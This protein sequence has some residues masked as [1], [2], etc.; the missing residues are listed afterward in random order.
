MRLFPQYEIVEQTETK[1]VFHRRNGLLLTLFLLFWVLAFGGIPLGMFVLISS[2]HGVTTLNCQR[3]DGPNKINCEWSQSQYLGLIT[4]VQDRPIKQVTAVK[5]GSAQWSNGQGGGTEKVWVSMAT[6][7]GTTRL[8]ETQFAIESG[9]QPTWQPKVA[10]EV[11]AFLNSQQASL[12]LSQDTRLSSSLWGS[13]PI[14]LP[15]TIIA[16]LVAYGGLRSQTLILDKISNQ[17]KVNTQTILGPR[18][19]TYPLDGVKSIKVKERW[20]EAYTYQLS[21]SFKSGKRYALP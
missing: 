18:T 19:K 14:F 12:T 5:L 20:D 7:T 13:T 16:V 4:K 21:F 9:Y 3:A 2:E 1:L 11:Q 6:P 10:Q 15:F 17:F 8:F